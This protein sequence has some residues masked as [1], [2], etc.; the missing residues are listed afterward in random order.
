MIDYSSPTFP[1]SF[2]NQEI[3]NFLLRPNKKKKE[4]VLGDISE[5][6]LGWVGTHF[7]FL[8]KKYDLLRNEFNF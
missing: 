7:F 4:D 8:E 1:C 5:K 2:G 3:F 6:I